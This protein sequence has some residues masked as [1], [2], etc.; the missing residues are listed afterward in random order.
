MWCCSLMVGWKEWQDV[1]GSWRVVS[2]GLDVVAGVDCGRVVRSV[3]GCGCA[4]RYWRLGLWVVG[5][6]GGMRW[7]EAA[8]RGLE[9]VSGGGGGGGGG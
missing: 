2:M 7:E 6:G 9:R 8:E 3:E 4:T 1:V 5:W